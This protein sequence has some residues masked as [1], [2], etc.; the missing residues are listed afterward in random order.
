VADLF[1][2]GSVVAT[3]NVQA[4]QIVSAIQDVGAGRNVTAIND[5]VAG[6]AVEAG[7]IVTSHVDIGAGHD[8][9]AQHD[10]TAGNNVN[11]FNQVRPLT[12]PT[13]TPPTPTSPLGTHVDT[14][15]L[16]SIPGLTVLDTLGNR[17]T[18]VLVPTTTGPITHYDL[19][20]V[21]QP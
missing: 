7:N 18:M 1:V 21:L 16:K 12:P 3:Q 4:G 20:F 19:Y 8:V 9:V 11:A 6:N 2:Q 13:Y 15:T 17:Y 5:V 14:T 10:L